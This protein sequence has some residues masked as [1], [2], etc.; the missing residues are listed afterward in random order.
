MIQ[1]KKLC[2]LIFCAFSVVQI[3]SHEE[4]TNYRVQQNY[5][6]T[7]YISLQVIFWRSFQNLEFYTKNN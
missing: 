7:D 1:K 5:Y 4:G 2:A 3:I 6:C